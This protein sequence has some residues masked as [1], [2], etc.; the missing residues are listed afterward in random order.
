[1]PYQPIKVGPM[2]KLRDALLLSE[3]DKDSRGNWA[4]FKTRPAGVGT[5]TTPIMVIP[6]DGDFS[7]VRF[8]VSGGVAYREDCRRDVRRPWCRLKPNDRLESALNLLA[9][10]NKEAGS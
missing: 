10:A 5:K 4:T 8:Y 7:E 3:C 9:A 6:A 1:M 2:D